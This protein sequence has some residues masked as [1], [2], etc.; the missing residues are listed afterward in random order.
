MTSFRVKSEGRFAA[1]GF[2]LIASFALSGAPVVAQ[3]ANMLQAPTGMQPS[4]PVPESLKSDSSSSANLAPAGEAGPR[5][6]VPPGYGATTPSSGMPQAEEPAGPSQFFPAGKRASE[7]SVRMLSA[8]PGQDNS[9]IQIGTLTGVDASTAGLISAQQG[10]LGTDMWQGASRADIDRYLSRLPVPAR[11]PVMNDLARRLLLT[12]AQPPEGASGGVSLLA[13]RLNRLIA[14]GQTQ[15]ALDLGATVG[16]ERG[17]AVAAGI[18]RAAL[19]Q[20]DDRLACDALKDIPPGNDPAHDAM[21]A[22]SVKLSAY[23]QIAA[24]NT[25]IASL[26]LDLAREEGMDDALFYSLA[27]EAAAGITLRAPEPN[28]LTIVDTAF[29]R[30]ADRELPEN[31]VEIVEP[32]LLQSMLA[33]PSVSDE[34]KVAAAERAAA[35]GLLDGRDLAAFYRKPSFT[36]EQMAGLLTSDIPESSSLRRAMIFQSISMAAAADE[37]IHLFKLAFATAESAGLYYPTV[38]ALYPELDRMVPSDA[39][40]PLAPA[41]A[42][43]FIAIGERSRAQDW[44]SLISSGGQMLGRDTRELTGLMRVSGG[45]P[46]SFDSEKTSAEIVSDL[47]SGVKATQLY[48]A[49]EAMMLEALGFQLT[50]AVWDALLDARGALTGDVPPEALL[51][52]LQAAGQKNAVGETVLLSL[53]AIGQKGPGTVHPR[54]S[55]QAVASLKAVNLESEARRLALEALMARSN[56][57]R[58]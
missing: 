11:S 48:A 45:S 36:P 3:E 41:A 6:I 25:E 31:A 44:L 35:Y 51:N 24:G 18:A 23:C 49:S 2:A 46:Q 47:K 52:R 43:A 7:P 1:A 26:T 32:A 14:A 50:P 29:Y 54:A 12:G 13:I 19:A 37:R 10:G 17:P 4:G 27:S 58:G 21:A 28:K 22:F 9:G 39:L 56:A 15:A 42:R 8:V 16:N 5:R 55:A 38:E 34:M 20:G 40:R 53:D 57:G 30:L 33:D